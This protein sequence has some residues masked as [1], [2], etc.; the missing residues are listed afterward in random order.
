MRAGTG[1]NSTARNSMIYRSD[2]Q[3]EDGSEDEVGGACGGYVL[4][5]GGEA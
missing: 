5:F 4:E 2:R 1:A 3:G